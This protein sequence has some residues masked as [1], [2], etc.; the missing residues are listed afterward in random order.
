MCGFP[1]PVD[2]RA[3]PA[4]N[5]LFMGGQIPVVV[6][7]RDAKSEVFFSRCSRMCRIRSPVDKLE[8]LRPEAQRGMRHREHMGLR[9]EQQLVLMTALRVQT[10]EKRLEV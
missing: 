6:G 8:P 3:W 10:L 4:V 1:A 5:A 2:R 7:P 9:A